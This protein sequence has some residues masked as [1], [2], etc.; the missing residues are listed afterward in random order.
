M[1]EEYFGLDRPPFKI[2][3]D[4]SLFFEGGKRGDIL[5]A[6]VYAIHRGEGIIKV[7]GEV[8]SGKTMLCRMLQ[9][10][11]PDTVEI[12]YIANP[13][14]SADDILYVIA[15]ELELAVEE[16]ASKHQVMHMLQDYL[17]QRHMENRQVVLFVEEAQG[18]PLETL[19]EIRL[20]SNLETDEHKLLQIILFG[21]PELD[22]NLAQQSIRQLRERITHNFE[23]EPLT[24]NEIHTYLNFRMRLVGYTGPEL[25]NSSVAK[26]VEQHSAGLLR[27]INI[28]ADK[29]L[30]SAFAEGTH[31]LGPKH[32]NAAVND[33]AFSQGVPHKST[34]RWW[35]LLL[36]AI[37]L[38]AGLYQ[39]RSH[40]MTIAGVDWLLVPEPVPES[41]PASSP[42]LDS[43]GP[44]ASQQLPESVSPVVTI[45][46][47]EAITAQ[48]APVV[49]E[50]PAGPIVAEI[51]VLEQDRQSDDPVAQ[52]D[53]RT[54]SVA[55]ETAP[56][57]QAALQLEPE[58]E[59][60]P[61]PEMAL[62]AVEPAPPHTGT[63]PVEEMASAEPAQPALASARL[64]TQESTQAALPPVSIDAQIDGAA[65]TPDYHHWLN[66]KLE[67]SR[68]WLISPERR[69]LSIQVMM[70]KKSAARELVYYLR[71]EWP[72]DISQ[73]YIYEVKIEGRPIYRVFYSEFDSLQEARVQIALLPDSVKVNAPYVHSVNRMRKALL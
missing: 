63:V 54:M 12:V 40:W 23:L 55:E 50:G 67:L 28:I 58:V 29:I 66:E 34:K 56:P 65:A 8:G 36:A 18:M 5:A 6:L 9:L 60:E 46:P 72:L 25:I 44:E 45:E 3:P 48:S 42:A 24:Q 38:S 7:V 35:L 64:Q 52:A 73:T 1:Y 30:L 69:E 47:G 70:R 39:T 13:S 10:K 49:E 61:E 57:L 22:Q 43:S 19:E 2:T 20:L 71:S 33:S 31:N 59:P 68:Q 53:S 21:Q 32:V 17:L 27:R 37:V 62:G 15:H 4:T 16:N 51:E 41:P 11:V 14:V 26:K